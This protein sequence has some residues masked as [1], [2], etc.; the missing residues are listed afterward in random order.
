MVVVHKFIAERIISYRNVDENLGISVTKQDFYLQSG[1]LG[2]LF[3]S[4]IID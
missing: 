3:T 2:L 4:V 1:I